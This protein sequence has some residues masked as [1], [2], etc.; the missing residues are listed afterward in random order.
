MTSQFKP[1]ANDLRRA[2]EQQQLVLVYQP[3]VSPDGLSIVGAE[4]LIR[5]HRPVH[6]SV[7][8]S[9]FVGLAETAGLIVELGRYALGLAAKEASGWPAPIPVAVNISPTHFVRPDFL[10]DV[11][12]AVA[13]S[14]LDPTRL[15]IEVVETAAFA[16]LQIAIDRIK[17]LRVHGISVAMDDFGAEFASLSVLQAVLFDKVKID[18]FFIDGLPS[19]R[20]VAILQAVIAL[21]R[22]LGLKVTAE[23]VETAEQHRFLRVSSVHSLQGYLFSRPVSAHSLREMLESGKVSTME[24]PVLMRL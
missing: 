7:G 4:A 14:G 15:E 24:K 19:I 13:R 11:D 2:I 22:A 10:S 9:V 18:K 12:Q 21:V 3:Q 17:A 6:G 5:W 16:N 8:P 20:S 1:T 23:G